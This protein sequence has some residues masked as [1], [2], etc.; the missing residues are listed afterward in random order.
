MLVWSDKF[1]TKINIVD[2]QH[3]NLV[4]L[5]NELFENIDS[6]EI[7]EAKLDNI[8]KQLLEYANKHF[9]DEEML[10][11]ENNLDMR[12]RSIHRMEHHSFIYDTQHMRS[13]TKPDESISEIAGKLAEFITNWLTFHILGMD[14][15]M[16]S[17]IAA[18]QHGMTPEQAYESQKT[19]HQD[20]AT[21]HL[22]LESVILM[23][24]KTTERCYELEEK[25]AECSKS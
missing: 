7:S 5:L 1:E 22:L 2:T 23:W 15:T 12:H 3:K 16:A 14:Q 17:Q 19:S 8:L 4:S 10:M 9:V 20:A 13:Y 18:I 24:R 21:T 25:L 6:G 11:L